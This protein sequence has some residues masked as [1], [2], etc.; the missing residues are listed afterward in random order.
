MSSCKNWTY[1]VRLKSFWNLLKYSTYINWTR[2]KF[3][4]PSKYSLSASTLLIQSSFYSCSKHFGSHFVTVI[5]IVSLTTWAS[6][7]N[8]SPFNMF[9][10]EG[11]G[12]NRW[13]RVNRSDVS[14]SVVILFL[15]RWLRILT[16]TNEQG[17]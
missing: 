12:S 10:V 11:T 13:D 15:A 3:F 14:S 5:L 6:V 2:I 16:G 9:T 1:Y 7:N 4:F 17:H 8:C